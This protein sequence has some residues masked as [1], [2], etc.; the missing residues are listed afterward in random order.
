MAATDTVSPARAR[1]SDR[2]KRLLAG[3]EA[4]TGPATVHRQAFTGA[5]WAAG[6]RPEIVRLAAGVANTFRMMPAVIQPD[7]LIVG[8][9]C[10]RQVAG[11]SYRSG[12]YC[13]EGFAEEVLARDPQHAPQVEQLLEAWRGRTTY[14]L[15]CADRSRKEQ[16]IAGSNVLTAGAS[17]GPCSLDLEAVLSKGV[18]GLQAEIVSARNRLAAQGEVPPEALGLYEALL[19][20]ADGIIEF[21]QNHSLAARQLAQRESDPNRRQELRLMAAISR[22]MPAQPAATFHEA[23]QS[24]WFIHLLD[25]CASLG[26]ADQLLWPY[27]KRDLAAGELSL[28]QAQEL[29]DCLWLKLSETDSGSVCLGGP[30]PDGSEGASPVTE[31]CLSAQERLGRGVSV[32]VRWHLGASDELLERACRIIAAARDGMTVCND[33]VVVAELG[34]YGIPA[35]EARDYCLN[36]CGQVD[37]Q[38]KSHLGWADGEVNLAKCLELALNDGVCRRTGQAL[39]PRTG[40]PRQ[41][42]SYYHMLKAFRKQAEHFA[43]VV[44]DLA[45]RAQQVR[46]ET[47]PNLVRTLLVADCIARARTYD[48]GGARDNGGHILTHGLADTASSLHAIKRAVFE[49]RWVDMPALIEALDADFQGHEDLLRQLHAVNPQGADGSEAGEV[50]AEVAGHWLAE[51]RKHAA[52]RG[53]AYR[54]GF[55]LPSGDREFGANC[56]ALPNGRRAWAPLAD[57]VPTQ[58][59]DP[60][61]GTPGPQLA[62][63]LAQG[64]ACL[65]LRLRLTSVE[66]AEG[67]RLEP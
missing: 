31:L 36:G 60:S 55:G 4:G 65:E 5:Y 52:W 42:P 27:L 20:V 67:A 43:G 19:I 13:D 44:C 1:T 16:A 53:G 49:E 12:V 54:A 50:A 57:S 39:G 51:V 34:S 21:A 45:N 48:G 32:A 22:R 28:A 9:D 25:G 58:T 26:R 3:L 64:V 7:E 40:D 56:G 61:T 10:L 17:G 62:G 11:F 47:A 46:G 63:N 2:V 38:G 15:I 37:I 14:A 30:R 59:I 35:Q 33:D 24:L 41:S 18:S 8:R 23:L 29:V 6:R 66:G